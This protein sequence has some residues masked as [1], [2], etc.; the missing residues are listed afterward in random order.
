MSKTIKD[1]LIL[2]SATLFL[3]FLMWLPHFLSLNNF[4]GL[5][6]TNG[7]AT[8][9]R[10]FDGLEY[11]IIAKTFYNSNLIAGIPQSLPANYYA[12][13]FIGYSL[14]ILLFAPLVGFL[15]S[16]LFVSLLFTILSS[17]SFYFLLKNFRLTTQPLFLSVVFL[18][19]PAR[20][21]I[22]H[23]V[24]SAEPM[25][26]FF[27]ITSIYFFM[28]YEVAKRYNFLLLSVL[29]AIGAQVTRPPGALLSATF[30]LYVLWK[31]YQDIKPQGFQKAF[32][33]K[34]RFLPLI[35]IPLSLLGIFYYYGIV[36][37]DFWAY[38]HS[39]D[40]IH[41]VFPPFQVFNKHQFW[42]G[43]IWLE[44]VVLIFLLGFLG[45]LTLIKQKLY[46]MAFFVLVY[47][48]ASTLVTHRDISRYTL[49]IFPFILIAFEKVLITKEFKIVL[50]ILSLG[51]YLYAQN[52]IIE[53]TS[54]IANL[55][56][57][58]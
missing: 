36:Y 54:P 12:A 16:M 43:D 14:V 42:V 44:D 17:F 11:V 53:N 23:S 15:K 46:L 40:N 5:N 39:G 10:N 6:F 51:I 4:L 34:L 8:I 41:L 20:W 52:F 57:Y 7:F 9:Y 32:L 29:L 26:I 1:L 21:L 50:V 48:G 47:L 18:V 28:K 37:N 24:G 33:D 49:P 19:L 2:A 31:L 13:H 55:L 22:V 30:A 25:F 45:G 27:V 3:T 56:I 38:F 58:N 35:L